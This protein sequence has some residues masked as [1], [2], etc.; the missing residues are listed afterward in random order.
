M[1]SKK[2]KNGVKPSKS[3]VSGAQPRMFFWL[4][5]LV[6]GLGLFSLSAC[7]EG[8]TGLNL[9]G[10]SPVLYTKDSSLDGDLSFVGG[11]NLRAIQ[12]HRF[13]AQG[14]DSLYVSTSSGLYILE[15][16]TL[17]P[18]DGPVWL[19]IPNP[20][21]EVST[22]RSVAFVLPGGSQ[23][24]VA[25]IR[26]SNRID[27]Y[28]RN[29]S[30]RALTF[31]MN[32]PSVSGTY[33]DLAVANSRSLMAIRSGIAQTWNITGGAFVQTPSGGVNTLSFAKRVFAANFRNREDA[34]EDF[35]I[36]QANG[37]AF[38]RQVG[39]D[40]FANLPSLNFPSGEVASDAVLIDLDGN[41]RTGILVATNNGLVYYSNV[42]TTSDLVFNRVSLT[43]AAPGQLK[44][45]IRL[46]AVQANPD[47]LKDVLAWR[48]SGELF[49]LRAASVRSLL[50]STNAS[51]PSQATFFSAGSLQGLA[52]LRFDDPLTEAIAIV[53]GTGRLIF[54]VQAE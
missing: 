25:I 43:G 22:G 13:P 24:V 20:L 37:F 31:R 3:I 7:R 29:P 40:S 46:E 35:V 34:L 41:G 42:S 51:L 18:E 54:L 8:G 10:S 26:A 21:S 15:Y 16:G 28:K 9:G 11:T 5:S 52:P 33:E 17:D 50:N 39:P 6:L 23:Q 30:T 36:L 1:L 48:A 49:F 44:D 45:L 38:V 2:A 4:A 14:V 19:S 12:R 47:S 32:A 53:N 27:L